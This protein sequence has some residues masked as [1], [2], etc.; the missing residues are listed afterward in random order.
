[1]SLKKAIILSTLWALVLGSSLELSDQ[2]AYYWMWAKVPAL[3]YFDHP[4]LQAWLTGF[5]TELL[6]DAAWVVRLPTQLGRLLL[7]AA[8]YSW[9]KERGGRRVAE[10]TLWI[11]LP[12]FFLVG[13]SVVSL[14]DGVMLPLAVLTLYFTE[15]KNVWMAGLVLGF[16]ALGK[17]TAAL[18]IPGVIVGL[19][20]PFKERWREAMK[21]LVVS[22]LVQFPVLWWNYQH[23][24]ASF[25]F[26][27]R[28]RHRGHEVG[29][30]QALQNLFAFSFSQLVL[31]GL[32]FVLALVYALKMYRKAS[33]HK[34]RRGLSPLLWW[35]LPFFSVFALSAMKGEMR[36]YWT[37]FA[38][39]PIAY[40]LAR[41]IVRLEA[42]IQK[43][44]LRF[45][46]SILI[47]SYALL[48]TILYFP[49]GYVFK[50][51]TDVYRKYDIRF[52]PRGDLKGWGEWI[53]ED[54][55]KEGLWT[56]ERALLGSD[57]RV[58]AQVAWAGRLKDFS[59]IGTVSRYQNQFI[60]WP[61][62]TTERYKQAIFFGDNRRRVGHDFDPYCAHPLQW[63]KKQILLLGKLV[64]EID[65]S[66]CDDFK[67]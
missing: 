44:F 62:P 18:L 49:V 59:Q 50:P 1:M 15:K 21:A 60:F 10:I 56:A 14:P 28:D 66:L 48:S 8:L 38:F 29:V 41:C 53:A 3:C 67:M 19:G 35:T 58:A 12:A 2:E 27:L 63:K 17:W 36:F 31:G 7:L 40:F 57:F 54:L 25:L 45:Q 4:P 39:F 34:E 61:R 30:L 33:L 65:W 6:G 55:K 64:K 46:S 13:G 43:N 32:S 47:L 22:G 42:N 52:S 26:H 5:F 16:A 37:T 20:Y 24:W 23:D 11:V 9:A 51:L